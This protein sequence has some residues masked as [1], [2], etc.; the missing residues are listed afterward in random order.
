MPWAV[1]TPSRVN[2]S[3]SSPAKVVHWGHEH[4]GRDAR[5]SA[6]AAGRRVEWIERERPDTLPSPTSARIYRFEEEEAPARSA[7]A[8][9][10]RRPARPARARL[11]RRR[12][13]RAEPGLAGAEPAGLDRLGRDDQ[14]AADPARPGLADLRPHLAPRDREIHRAVAAM[15]RESQALES[16]LAIVA[17]RLA[18]ESRGAGRG[19]GAADGPGRR[20]LGP[21]RPGHPLSLAR[22][23]RA[24]PQGAGARRMPPPRPGSISAC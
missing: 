13:L 14:R 9:T 12:R 17:G 8:R 24:R 6:T 1:T 18:G 21:A 4:G 20:G 7:G 5:R 23:R 22:D 19:S 10:A 3:V 15:R 2:G 11:A 16:V